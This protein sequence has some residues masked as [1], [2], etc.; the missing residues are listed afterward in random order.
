VNDGKGW[1]EF[2]IE[3]DSRRHKVKIYDSEREEERIF[4]VS[5]NRFGNT[6]EYVITL[7]DITDFESEKQRL[8]IESTIDFSTKIYN[9]RAF[10]SYIAM[11]IEDM[12]KGVKRHPVS[13]ILFDIDRFKSINDN[14]GHGN[15]DHIL[16]RL[17]SL[18]Q[19][20]I[21]KGDFLARWGGDEFVIVVEGADREVAVGIAEKI[22]KKISQADFDIGM[23]VTCSFGVTQIRSGD[24]PKTLLA[25][26][27]G[28]LY[29]AKNSGRDRV[30]Y[31]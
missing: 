20:S 31:A 13:L 7:H 12:A 9:K 11:T 15:G 24:T 28:A 2:I 1:L 3:N 4:L 19:S 17:S 26:V 22:R 27:D 25:R 14:F 8:R 18:V 29:E 6:G 5:A 10:E 30:S 16:L 23:A 21:R